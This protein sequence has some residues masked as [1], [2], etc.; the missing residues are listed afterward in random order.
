MTSPANSSLGLPPSGTLAGVGFLLVGIVAISVQ[1][2]LIKL[3]SGGYPLHQIVMARSGIGIFFSLLLVQYEGGWSILRTRRPGLHAI[4]CLAVVL[5]NM[6]YFVALS[7]IPLAD[8]TALFFAAPL[9]ITV[10]SIP[11]LGEK[12][13]PWRMGAVLV[14]LIG[15]I[16]M[17]RPW[18]EGEA[19][20]ANRLVL[21]LP[22]IAA[23][24]YAL[25]QIMTRRLGVESKASAMTIYMQATFIL[26]SLAFW[27]VAGDGRFVDGSTDPSLRFLLRAWVWPRPGDWVILGSLGLMT[28]LIGYCLNQAY[29]LSDA[30]VVAPFEYSALPLA[31]FWGWWMFGDLPLPPVWLG[32][33]LIV[34]AGL[35][36]FVRERILARRLAR[37][38][39]K[40]RY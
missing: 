19:L 29:R 17:Q 37:G 31:V 9:F 39:I 38:P 34:S 25:S 16:L 32:M 4:R 13:G 20:G 2:M 15:V 30:A 1:D 27:L 12:V 7:V 10:L 11:I 5:A 22:V 35:V 33:G 36:V 40:S 3:L 21:L 8:A 26:V 6:T 18:A 14:G 23:L 28:T 24:G